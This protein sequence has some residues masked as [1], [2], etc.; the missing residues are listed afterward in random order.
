MVVATILVVALVAVGR[1]LRGAGTPPSAQPASTAA[2][3]APYRIG[4]RL[5]CPL[6]R[7]VLATSDGRAYPPGHPA[8]PAPDAVPMAC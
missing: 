1:S 5:V 8:L 3:T 7:P 2:A 4:G 6:A